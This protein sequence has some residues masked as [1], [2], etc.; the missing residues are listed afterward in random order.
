MM[1]RISL[2]LLATTA[3][4]V[5][6]CQG[7]LAADIL[8]KAPPPAPL[9]PPVQDWSGVYVG[10]EGG[11]GWGHQN[12]TS[13]VPFILTPADTN[14]TLLTNVACGAAEAGQAGLD[15]NFAELSP[16]DIALSGHDQ[17]GGVVGGFFGVQ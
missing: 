16:T 8:R 6:A 4:G 2:T 12:V 5:V 1:R 7:A 9:P 17:S 11:Y 15:S 14:C 13:N 3:I 10:L